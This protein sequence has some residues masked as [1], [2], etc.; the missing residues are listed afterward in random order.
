MSS[1]EY[2]QLLKFLYF[3]GY[4]E[5]YAEAEELLESMSDEH[6][7]ELVRVYEENDDSYL[8]KNMKKRETNNKK[9]LE[10][11]KKTDAYKDMVATVRKKFDEEKDMKEAWYSGK[12]QQRTTASGRKVRWDEDDETDNAVSDRLQKQRE[13]AAKKA[14]DT[15]PKKSENSML[16]SVVE[17]LF[18]EGYAD[19]IENAEVM[20]ENISETWTNEIL[21]TWSDSKV[22]K[23]PKTDKWEA[24]NTWGTLHPAAVSNAAAKNKYQ[25]Q[26][27]IEAKWAKRDAA[28]NARSKNKN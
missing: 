15:K 10:D 28:E 7:E 26:K 19:T 3:E 27:E 25:T 17:Y 13:A 21:E 16:E 20:A 11:M 12:G 2:N 18:V 14:K 24:S 6:F 23:N 22:R 4:V 5:S 9:A 1:N 8:E